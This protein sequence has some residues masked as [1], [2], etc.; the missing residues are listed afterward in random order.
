ML[1]G[2]TAGAYAH[3][4]L[5]H[6]GPSGPPPRI[7]APEVVRAAD[8]A[9]PAITTSNG[10]F[11]D[12]AGNPVVLH[13]VD[14]AITGKAVYQKA[15][16]LHANFVRIVAPWSLF[17]PVKPTGGVHHW[18]AKELAALDRE[19]AFFGREH[20]NVLI[21]FHQ[22]RWSPYFAGHFPCTTSDC[23]PKGVPGW[24]YSN[25]RFP[26]SKDGQRAAEAAFWTSEATSSQHAY[27]A[28]AAMMA[29]HFAGD[30]NVIGYEVINEP[31]AGSLDAG[32][33]TQVMLRWQASILKVLH[34]VDPTRTV[35]VMCN[36]GGSGVG[37]ADLRTLGSL[38]HVALDWHDYYNGRSGGGLDASGDD[39]VPSWATTH[40]QQATSY[41]GTAANQ[42]RVLAWPVRTAQRFGIPLLIGEWGFRS[43]APGW[44]TY[45]SQM[46]A[47]FAQHH[48][49]N[50][51]WELKQGGGLALLTPGGKLNVAARQIA[52][53]AG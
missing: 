24:F 6:S 20:V 16:K 21:D 50:A 28:F 46:L 11:V 22:Y 51:R 2:L 42:A 38:D 5:G 48:V 7:P 3:G 8:I 39:W 14:V 30:P 26:D 12:A 49:S 15:L 40:N 31:H 35:F 37:T 45:Q 43:D 34:T 17:E 27:A 9:S 25:G 10:Q 52:Q 41:T 19:V 33:A 18:D 1:L 23:L 13:G 53:A 44:D 32:N 29:T 47:L 4:R 36:G